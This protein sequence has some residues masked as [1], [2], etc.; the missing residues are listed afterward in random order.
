MAIAIGQIDSTYDVVTPE[1][2][3]FE[4]QMAGPLR[5][6]PAFMI[7]VAIRV[8]VFVFA[9][10]VL[11][12]LGAFTFNTAVIMNMAGV[13]RLLWFVLAW[14]YGGLFETFWNGQTPGKWLTGIRVLSVQGRPINGLQAV[15]RNILR[16]VDSMPLIPYAAFAMAF[17]WDP[18]DPTSGL[19]AS[20]LLFWITPLPMFLVGLTVPAFNR[21]WQRLGDLVCGTMVIVEQRSWQ[22]GVVRL[23]DE[24]VGQL[25]AEL[26]HIEVSRSLAKTLAM[27]VERRKYFSPARRQEIAMHLGHVLIERYHL[28]PVAD[29][30]LLLCALYFNVFVSEKE[31]DT[32]PAEFK[33]SQQDAIEI[34][35][36]P[37]LER[38]Q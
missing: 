25:A 37:L 1:N 20:L 19:P 24:R 29:H 13:L 15:M 21:R 10:V 14:F 3:A 18:M 31:A 33:P 36:G 7:D 22:Y 16:F 6:M 38:R 28:P 23:Q 26:P 27:Y 34:V 2:I 4:Y 8:A 32:G 30:D 9:C 35:T 11:M 17:H 5:R 12:A